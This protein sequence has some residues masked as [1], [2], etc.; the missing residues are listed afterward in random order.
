MPGFPRD[1]C[2]RCGTCCLKGGPTLHHEDK[3]LLLNGHAGYEHLVTIRKGEAVFDPVLG[4]P[5]PTGHELVK[6]RGKGNGWS[7]CLFD[8]RSSACRVYEHRFLECRLLKCWDPADLVAV[9]GVHTIVRTDV[10]NPG[11][12]VRQVIMA[13]EKE[14]PPD[15]V[16]VLIDGLSRGEDRTKTLAALTRL[17]RRDLAVRRYAR[18]EMG[19][20]AE[21]EYFIFGRPLSRILASHGIMIHKRTAGNPP[22]KDRS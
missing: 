2:I 8:E 6:V 1:S 17:A 12:P 7:C 14:C 11:D 21:H 18:T 9:I 22:G 20:R 5:R 10:I 3:K 16:R 19:L 13:H 4:A 15:E